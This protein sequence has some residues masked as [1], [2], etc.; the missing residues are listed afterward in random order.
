MSLNFPGQ[1]LQKEV[2]FLQL[3]INNLKEEAEAFYYLLFPT[4]VQFTLDPAV[5]GV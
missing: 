1:K 5:L 2:F 4:E 3:V